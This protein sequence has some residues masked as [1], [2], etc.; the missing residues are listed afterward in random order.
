M[1]KPIFE[2]RDKATG[3]VAGNDPCFLLVVSH[4]EHSDVCGNSSESELPR[5]SG[6]CE[7]SILNESNLQAAETFATNTIPINP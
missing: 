5:I 6:A 4:S 1:V 7:S 3:T 2:S